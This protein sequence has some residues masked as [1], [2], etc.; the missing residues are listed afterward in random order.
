MTYIQTPADH[1]AAIKASAR[2]LH[3]ALV[4]LSAQIIRST[5]SPP[6]E[7]TMIEIDREFTRMRDAAIDASLVISHVERCNATATQDVESF[8]V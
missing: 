7:M 3:N 4:R 2:K 6:S 1:D 8:I 5:C